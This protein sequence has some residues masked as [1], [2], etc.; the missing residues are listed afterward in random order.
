MSK[1]ISIIRLIRPEQW[2]KNGFIFLP[3]FFGGQLFNPDAWIEGCIT[4]VAFSL[5]ASAI[6]CIND[7]KD[8]EADR[9]HPKKCKRPIAYGAVSVNTAISICLILIALSL[10]ASFLLLDTD[11]TIAVSIV[12]IS[13]LLLNIA[14]CYKLKYIGIVDVLVIAIGFV[15]RLV[16]GGIAEK[17]ELS[18]W[19]VLMT[20]L[21][22]LF[23]AFAKRRD[24]VI[25]NERNGVVV[26]R[27]TQGYNL[28]F[29]N[30][31]LIII[32]SVT[33]VCYLIYSVSPDVMERLH[34]RFVYISSIFVLAGI[35]R[36]LQIALVCENSGSPTKVLVK[37]RFIQVSLIGWVLFFL[38]IIY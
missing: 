1:F 24:D 4:F 28:D 16:S 32:A 21:I 37:D 33:M 36:Y 14:Y 34:S 11:S 18:P 9:R 3:L 5:M 22:A 19:I 35:L 17:I 2:L 30:A 23:L 20:F 10:S 15:L 12:L 7:L 29:M 8:A 27:S 26:R 38:I 31:T 25:L 13:Y 6:Y